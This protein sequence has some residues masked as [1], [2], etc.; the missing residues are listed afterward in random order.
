MGESLEARTVALVREWVAEAATL[1][2]NR[3]ARRLA[4]LLQ[5]PHGLEFTVGFADGVIRPDDASVSARNLA[6]LSR[7]VPRFLPL[8]MRM[9]LRLGG[10]LAPHA[11]WLVIPIARL[12]LRSMVDHLLLDADGRRLARAI[13]RLRKQGMQ[14]NLNLLGEAVL[15]SAEAARR[16]AGTYALLARDDVDYVSVKVSS[17]IAPHSP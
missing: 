16:L 11:P 4:G 8:P 5:D 13:A 3:P 7:Q 12:T 6:A 10:L 1:P 15:G 17:V 9:L 14:L 2:V